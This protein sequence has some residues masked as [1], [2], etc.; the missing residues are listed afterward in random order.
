M[1]GINLLKDKLLLNYFQFPAR[2]SKFSFTR[3]ASE[4]NWQKNFNPLESNGTFPKYFINLAS[5]SQ[6]E[7]TFSKNHK[8]MNLLIPEILHSRNYC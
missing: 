6:E 3:K 2:K 5:A 7:L 8:Q 4:S 1:Y